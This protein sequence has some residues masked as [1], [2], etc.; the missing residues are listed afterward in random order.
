MPRAD[1]PCRTQIGGVRS[2]TS[3]SPKAPPAW[4]QARASRAAAT[5]V[6]EGAGTHEARAHAE[7]AAYGRAV[8]G[9]AAAYR[10]GAQVGRHGA[11]P[12]AVV[13]G[14][15]VTDRLEPLHASWVTLKNDVALA[16]QA[17]VVDDEFARAF[18]RDWDAWSA[19]Y[20]DHREDWTDLRTTLGEIETRRQRL[21]QWREALRSRGGTVTGPQTQAPP[22]GLLDP[23]RGAFGP[24]GVG[25]FASSLATIVVG[26]GV[27]AGIALVA[28]KT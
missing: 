5:R 25:G 12:D 27:I 15:A 4:F 18:L 24:G 3:S 11:E 22:P 14:S 13:V 26:V 7:A 6:L 16:Q 21:E 19:F 20:N 10:P 28:S 9:G 2:S 17:D 1:C 23:E 8:Y